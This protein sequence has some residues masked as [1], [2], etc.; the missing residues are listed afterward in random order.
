[1]LTCLA[2]K[3]ENQSEFSTCSYNTRSR[4]HIY[5]AF[6]NQG[7]R[8]L[9]IS[10]NFKIYSRVSRETLKTWVIKRGQ[11]KDRTGPYIHFLHRNIRESAPRQRIRLTRSQ[12]AFNTSC[13]RGAPAGTAEHYRILFAHRRERFSPALPTFSSR[14]PARRGADK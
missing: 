2:R 6:K 1:M 12:S 5:S 11:S 4:V 8:A 3:R 13:R 14:S 7:A 9:L 10:R